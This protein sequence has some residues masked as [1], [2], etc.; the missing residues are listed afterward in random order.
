MDAC[1]TIM[2]LDYT[3]DT[4]L[5]PLSAN[6]GPKGSELTLLP[7]C[8]SHIARKPISITC[9]IYLLLAFVQ[10]ESI[11]SDLLGTNWPLTL[12]VYGMLCG[13]LILQ[14]FSGKEIW[15]NFVFTLAMSAI[16]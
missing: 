2:G 4:D 9:E 14:V 5:E 16:E 15:R 7:P 8:R 10:M 6:Y 3:P 12:K 1:E 13:M 11:L